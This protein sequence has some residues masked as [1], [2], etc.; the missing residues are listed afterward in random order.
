MYRVLVKD[1]SGNYTGSY[2][3]KVSGAGRIFIDNINIHK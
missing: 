2:N 3:Y 1:D